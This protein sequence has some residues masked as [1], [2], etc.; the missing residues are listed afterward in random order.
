MIKRLGEQNAATGE[1]AAE[2]V[3]GGEEAGSVLGVSQG[4]V[5]KDALHDN[6]GGAA[7]NGD[8]NG[9]HDPVNIGAGG[10]GEKEEADGGADRGGK[11]RDETGFLNWPA[12]AADAR[13]HIVVDI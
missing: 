4:H 2:E 13:V 3:V 8:T 5:D 9:G 11:C 10:P 1:G 7:V 6:E 12:M